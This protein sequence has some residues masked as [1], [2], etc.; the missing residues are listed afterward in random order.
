MKIKHI[1]Q[2]I[3]ARLRLLALPIARAAVFIVYFYFGVLKLAGESPA[4]PLAVALTAKTIGVVHFDAAFKLLA[5]FECLIGILFLIPKA[6]RIV[7]PMLLVHLLI[8]C[9]PLVLVPELAW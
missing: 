8:V 3:I 4:S 2:T 1:D 5:V 9:S 7:V 6:I